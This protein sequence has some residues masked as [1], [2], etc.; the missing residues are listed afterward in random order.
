MPPRNRRAV[1]REPSVEEEERDEPKNSSLRSFFPLEVVRFIL[2]ELGGDLPSLASVCLVSFGCLEEASGELYRDAVVNSDRGMISFFCGVKLKRHSR[3]IP[4]LSLEQVQTLHI[5]CSAQIG[6]SPL[7]P[8]LVQKRGSLAY[9]P[10]RLDPPLSLSKLSISP[11]ASPHDDI[12]YSNLLNLTNDIFPHLKPR[13]VHFVARSI[14][15][16][17]NTYGGWFQQSF[18]WTRTVEAWSSELRSLSVTGSW[19]LGNT[20]ANGDV[21]L[22]P[23]GLKRR[24]G[25]EEVV[26]SLNM[27]QWGLE[28]SLQAM[29]ELCS[30]GAFELK[31]G[32]RT[33]LAVRSS[34]VEKMKERLKGIFSEDERERIG[35]VDGGSSQ[36]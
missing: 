20:E 14:D 12:P 18:D 35:V 24:E 9:F 27:V 28:C 25:S 33:V 8:H 1:A 13:D 16:R 5:Y 17:T 4:H 29:M 2:L 21:F 31:K 15:F 34:L 7:A 10:P 19:P 22:L 3:L 11:L 32:M 26:F 6:S 30:M 36:V 23:I